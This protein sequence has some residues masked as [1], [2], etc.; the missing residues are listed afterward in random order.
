MDG[1]QSRLFLE[2]FL[3]GD[4][5]ENCKISTSDLDILNSLE[6]IAVNSE[7]GFT[8]S[9][10][11]PSIGTKT[12]YVLRL[13]KHQDTY[14]QEIKKVDYDGVIWCPHTINETIIARRKL[15]NTGNTF[16]QYNTIYSSRNVTKENVIIGGKPQKIN[17]G[18]SRGDGYY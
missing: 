9:S 6:I 7:Y 15:F 18:F 1:K 16:Y 12:L 4:G 8:V 5:H 14:I 17:M 11:K 2:T 10:R 13:I 3:K